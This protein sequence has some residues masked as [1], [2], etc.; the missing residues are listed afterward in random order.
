MVWEATIRTGSWASDQHA[1]EEHRALAASQGLTIHA[2]PLAEGGFHVRA[3][4]GAPPAPPHAMG[5]PFAPPH[6]MGA[7]A[8]PPHAMGAPFAPPHGGSAAPSHAPPMA[9]PWAPPALPHAPHAPPAPHVAPRAFASGC[10]VCGC[11]GPTKQVTL[12][13]NIGVLVVRFPKTL[14]GAL[15]RYCIEKHFFQYTL[16]SMLFGWW[17]VISFF[18]TLVAIPLNVVTYLSAV[19]LPAPED[20]ERTRAHLRGKGSV[21]TGFGVLIALAAG[22]GLLVSVGMMLA[23]RVDSDVGAGAMLLGL[24]VMLLGLPAA[25]FLTFG[26]RARSRAAA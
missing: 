21:L 8:V 17:G 7:P 6:A 9:S 1:L 15:C 18:T 13:Q 10:D 5:A 14:R 25:L 16:V 12:M 4:P 11:E 2:V 3:L 19:G 20:A 24:V 22:L 23:P 26:I